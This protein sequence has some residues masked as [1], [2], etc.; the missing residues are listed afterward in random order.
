MPPYLRE[1]VN[2]PLTLKMSSVKMYGQENNGY[3]RR[4][5]TGKEE[6][7]VWQRGEKVR[8]VPGFLNVNTLKT[9]LF[10]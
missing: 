10:S 4:W 8:W 1:P 6:N 7:W 3:I 9:N 2:L 5:D